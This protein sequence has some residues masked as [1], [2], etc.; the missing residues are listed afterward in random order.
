[1]TTVVAVAVAVAVSAA[2]LRV[3]GPDALFGAG[4]EERVEMLSLTDGGAV[5]WR[6]PVQVWVPSL[7]A[8]KLTEVRGREGVR[9]RGAVRR[10]SP[11]QQVWFPKPD[12][13]GGWTDTGTGGWG[14]E[15]MDEAGVVIGFKGGRRP[16]GR[17]TGCG[18]VT[19]QLGE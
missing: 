9:W 6:R 3:L 16:G 18:L 19:A 10:P 4:L 5:V 14:G 12:G 1:M 7:P 15:E 2:D 8:D 13:D 11:L 17:S